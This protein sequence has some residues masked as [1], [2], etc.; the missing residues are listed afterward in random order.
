[1]CDAF[2]EFITAKK[3]FPFDTP[4]SNLRWN[5]C[6]SNVC[7]IGGR[8]RRARCRSCNSMRNDC[9][10]IS[11]TFAC[12]IH[13]RCCCCIALITT[14]FVYVDFEQCDGC[15]SRWI[16][17]YL[18]YCHM[19][20]DECSH[21]ATDWTLKMC[22]RNNLCFSIHWIHAFVENARQN[23]STVGWVRRVCH[24]HVKYQSAMS[25][26]TTM[27]VITSWKCG[28]CELCSRARA[29]VNDQWMQEVNWLNGEPVHGRKHRAQSLLNLFYSSK[30]R[31][32]SVPHC[33]IEQVIFSHYEMISFRLATIHPVRALHNAI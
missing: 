15:Q 33:M 26:T 2:N 3:A 24:T 22:V 11:R 17:R 20:V 31:I 8:Q 12:E 6:E 32:I 25:T 4:K 19:A 14:D 28:Q 27:I 1:M 23:G 18:H 7:V 16:L 10:Y 13:C 5:N 9:D 21:S 29:R 30:N